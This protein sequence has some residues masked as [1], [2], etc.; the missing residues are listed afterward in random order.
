MK[1]GWTTSS[2]FWSGLKIG[3]GK[4]AMFRLDPYPDLATLREQ[5]DGA[6][7][8]VGII[9]SGIDASHED[10]TGAVVQSV[11]V[12]ERKGKIEVEAR[13]EGA[14]N[15]SFGHGTAVASIIHEIA[16]G[17]ELVD[18][19]VLNEFNSC[20]GDILI[21][22]LEW[23]LGENIWVI[24]MSLATAKERFR[25]RIHELCEQAYTQGSL[26]VASKRNVGP[27]GFPALF[28]NV[29]SVDREDYA[30]LLRVHY[31][32]GNPV[33]F[34][35]RGTGV[36]VAAP[37]GGHTEMTG[38][39]FA[40]PHVTGFCALLKAVYHEIQPFEAKTILKKFSYLPENNSHSLV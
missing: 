16:P 6:G 39:S 1:P 11:Q 21:K 19:K 40:T 29:V 27:I 34:D 2:S 3:A 26:I 4:A 7:V 18:V 24:N 33:E 25:D 31:R 23:C 12:V 35:A 36:R 13:D 30:D 20:T 22:G 10:L 14:N 17:A 9:D 5:T 32:P 15:D 8:R 37:G 28:S 38:T